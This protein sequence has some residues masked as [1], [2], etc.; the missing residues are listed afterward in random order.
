MT[1]IKTPTQK[2]DAKW[3]EKVPLAIY[4]ISSPGYIFASIA[5]SKTRRGKTIDAA[6]LETKKTDVKSKVLKT[7]T[8][9]ISNIAA[10]RKN[11]TNTATL[12]A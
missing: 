7:E 6:R 12:A 5:E 1:E 9:G 3:T 11:A 10:N 8:L 4:L 2:N